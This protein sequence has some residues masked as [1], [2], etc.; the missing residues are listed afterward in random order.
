MA[1]P[2]LLPASAFACWEAAGQRYGV[3]P[4]LLYA[5]A[6]V[7][8]GLNPRAV[9]LSHR[10]RTGSHDIGLMQINSS[11]LPALQRLGIAERDLYEPC[12]NIH[13][14]AW[15]LAQSFARHGISWEGVGAYNAACS[16]LKGEACRSARSRYAWS[17]YRRLP[18]NNTS[19]AVREPPIAIASA[20]TLN[21]RVAP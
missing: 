5:I 8:S 9:N 13:V 6:R 16:Q 7:E 2:S 10:L 1:I 21:V 11:N 12:T 4:Q 19:A 17:V 20:R 3:S 18:A 15:L 14:G